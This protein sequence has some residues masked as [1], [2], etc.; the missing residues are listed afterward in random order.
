M[1]AEAIR[2]L[3]AEI[4]L[5]K[6]NK[7]LEK[8]MGATKSK[9]IRKKLAKRLKLVQGF[10]SSH[11]R[12]EWM[13]LDVLPVIPPDLRPLVSFE[14]G[15]VATSTLTDVYRRVIHHNNRFNNLLLLT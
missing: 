15:R 2:K 5:T 1:G 13:I 4:D 8:A 14:G 11:A 3:L 9:Q 6:L 12:P 7:E 10:Q